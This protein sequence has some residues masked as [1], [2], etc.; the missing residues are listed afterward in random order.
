[1]TNSDPENKPDAWALMEQADKEFKE[2]VA[3]T[4]YGKVIG[5]AT[6]TIAV[7]LKGM[8]ANF[9]DQV[10][11]PGWEGIKQAFQ[12]MAEIEDQTWGVVFQFLQDNGLMTKDLAARLLQFRNLPI[13]VNTLFNLVVI[14]G[15]LKEYTGGV[16]STSMA[17]M[18]QNMNAELRPNLPPGEAIIKAAFIAPELTGRVRDILRKQGLKEEDIDLLFISNYALYNVDTVRDLFL[19]KE[20]D[21]F[22]VYERLEEMGFTKVRIGEIMKTWALLPGAQD[23]IRMAVKEAFSPEIA[24]RFGQ[25]EDFPEEAAEHGTKIGLSRDWMTRYW[26][27]HWDLP[28]PQM[29]FE[30]LHRGVIGEDDLSLLLKALDVMPFWREKIKQISFVPYTRVDV[31]RMHKMGVLTDED[32]IKS[33]TDIGYDQEHAAKMAEFTILYNQG[34]DKELTRSQIMAAYADKL[35]SKEQ[36]REMVMNSGYTV[37]QVDF[38]ISLTDYADLKEYQDDIIAA[39]KDK[40]QNNLIEEIDARS[41]LQQLNL[42][43]IKV[44]SLL[45]RWKVRKVINTKMPSKTDLDKFLRYQIVNKDQYRQEMT[46]LGYSFYQTEWYLQLADKTAPKAAVAQPMEEV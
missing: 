27:A 29:G 39:I 42:P 36:V 10:L 23:L 30:M 25:Y 41:E 34:S 33:Y 21:E 22:A 15:I 38:M 40:F 1:M 16:I 2:S 7:L 18:L 31:R 9:Y 43:A 13:G 37:D 28:S 20:I 8:W 17:P 3:Q 19:R 4:S 11:I 44:D 5:S 14:G 32:L 46:R 26:A 35:I 45:T 24:Q 12:G 6:S